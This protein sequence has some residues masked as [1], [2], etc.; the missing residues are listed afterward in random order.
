MDYL[1]KLREMEDLIRSRERLIVSF[2]GGVDSA[3]LLK[4]SH[5]ML[6]DSAIA[7]VINDET[8]S[9]SALESAREFVREHG[10]RCEIVDITQLDDLN[11]AKN[12]ENRCYYCKKNYLKVLKEIAE[13]EGIHTIAD[14]LNVSDFDEHRPGIKASNE[15]G[16]WHPFVEAGLTKR[17]IRDIAK[18]MGL[19][20]WNK[21]SDACLASRI[22]Y[23]EKITEEGLSMIEGAESVL[24]EMGFLQLR[25]RLHGKIGRIEVIEEDIRKVLELRREI[26]LKLREIGFTYITLDL[27]GYRS[28]SMDEMLNLDD[29]HI[30]IAL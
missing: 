28:G 22:P 4:V 29:I 30:R 3:V 11:F 5:D 8:F 1:D 17:E 19:S 21:P 10:I 20:V 18:G 13:R 24:K 23:G 14:G 26:A 15:E 27:E 16:V 9:L 7:V 12:P 2:S 6:G 25:V